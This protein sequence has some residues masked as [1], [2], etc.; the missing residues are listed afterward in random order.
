MRFYEV[1]VNVDKKWKDAFS[2]SLTAEK[3]M[4]ISR[5]SN[6]FLDELDGNGCVFITQTSPNTEMGVCV[7]GN[8]LCPEDIVRRFLEEIDFVFTYFELN[9][10]SIKAFSLMVRASQNSEYIE[11]ERRLYRKLDLESIMYNTDYYYA[12]K[13]AAP[14]KSPQKI[15]LDLKEYHLGDGFAKEISRI[16]SAENQQVFR[17]NPTDYLMISS[18]ADQ[19]KTM[20]IDLVLAL[21]S[22]GR[23]ISKRYTIVD[24]RDR[25]CTVDFLEKIYVLNEGGSVVL[26]VDKENFTFGGYNKGHVVI[27]DVVKV[28]QRHGA[29]TLTIFSMD[30]PSDK[31]RAAIETS[32]RGM[33]LIVFTDNLYAKEKAV[34]QLVMLAARDGFE[35]PSEDLS[36]VKCS[37]KSYTYEELCGLYNEW[38]VGYLGRWVF[39]EYG[40]FFTS[41][42]TSEPLDCPHEEAYERLQKMIGLRHAKKVI[43]GAI[44]YFRLQKEYY[45]RG[46]EFTRPTMHMC[47]TGNPGTA[48]TTVARLFAEILKNNNILSRGEL[49]EVGRAQLVGQY[50]GSTAPKIKDIFKKAKGSV[51]FI[52]EAYSLVEDRKGLYGSEAI[53]TIV[54]EMENCRDDTIVILAGYHDEMQKLLDWN[55]GMRSRIAFHVPFD[56]YSKEELLGISKIFINDA[57][58]TLEKSAEEKLLGIFQRA[59]EDKNFGNGRFAR[60]LVERAKLNLANRLSSRDLRF[61][62]DE[63]IRTLKAE[64]FD[65]KFSEKTPSKQMGFYF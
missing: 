13:V 63:E 7:R 33:P 28:I 55:P 29:R 6:K 48:K 47:F 30:T 43:E 62:S 49:I 4:A 45:A 44:N 34:D 12:D 31:M 58:L 59:A 38:R 64:D 61:V 60:N 17:G 39:P 65:Y 16:F 35:L 15:L 40:E 53:N 25:F 46:I 27:D 1:S 9:E 19:R 18:A 8:G 23:L 51:L 41:H 26:K 10:V 37:D 36:K 3:K 54:Q 11:S 52:D 14:E 24:L 57:S 22:K 2:Q 21:Y 20:V 56:D 5:L 50:V 32:M 42:T